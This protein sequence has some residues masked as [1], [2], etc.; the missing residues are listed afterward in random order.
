MT[1][2]DN[3]SPLPILNN[4]SNT[5]FKTS[6]GRRFLLLFGG[7]DSRGLTS[8]KLVSIDL[9]SMKWGYENVKG[10]RVLPRV[11]AAMVAI[12]N[13]LFIFGGRDEISAE[14]TLR[15]S[16]SIAEYNDNKWTW[17]ATDVPYDSD[18]IHPAVYDA[19]VIPIYDGLKILLGPG[20]QRSGNTEARSSTPSSFV[21]VSFPTSYRLST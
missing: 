19:V 8:S 3:F 11:S 10:G 1:G 2:R 9:D 7:V 18:D 17:V 20:R 6:T 21:F 14:A 5:I 15:R 16:Y 12:K 4:A 13:R